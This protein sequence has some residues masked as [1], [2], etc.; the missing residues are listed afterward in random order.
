MR[1]HLRTSP[2]IAVKL[3]G[4]LY[5]RPSGNNNGQGTT[6]GGGGGQQQATSSASTAN[7]LHPACVLNGSFISQTFQILYR[8]ED[9]SLSD[10]AQF[11]LHVL[12]DSHKVRPLLLLL[13]HYRLE[14]CS[15]HLVLP[16][17][18]IDFFLL[19][20]RLL[21]LPCRDSRSSSLLWLLGRQQRRRAT[22][23]FFLSSFLSCVD[24]LIL[25]LFFDC[26]FLS[27]I[28]CVFLFGRF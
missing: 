16:V 12:V 28:F 2:K 26:C 20:S 15:T 6:T 23:F 24:Y 3:E 1:G 7:I 22:T 14:L 4:S 27:D 5:H 18:T 21:L 13:L 11:R 17:L 10:M 9:V 19:P 8:N 25:L